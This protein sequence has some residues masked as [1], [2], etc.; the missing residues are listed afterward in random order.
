MG[1]MYLPSLSMTELGSQAKKY[2]STKNTITV[3]QMGT[4]GNR[5]WMAISWVVA[6]LRGSVEPMAMKEQPIR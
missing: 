6:A 3:I 5:G 4:L 2:T 1:V